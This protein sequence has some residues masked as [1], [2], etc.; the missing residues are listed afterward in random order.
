MESMNEFGVTVIFLVWV[1]SASLSWRIM[2]SDLKYAQ[3]NSATSF[4]FMNFLFA[5]T[6]LLAGPVGVFLALFQWKL[7]GEHDRFLGGNNKLP[8]KPYRTEAERMLEK[9]VELN[10][11]AEDQ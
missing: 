10:N 7:R 2:C 1:C 11:S 4:T 3:D 6:Y 5:V 8:W 9:L